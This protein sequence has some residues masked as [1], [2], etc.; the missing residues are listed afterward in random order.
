MK[1]SDDFGLI[2]NINSVAGHV[3]PFLG[4]SLNMYAP[5]KHA[6]TALTETIRQELIIANNKKVRITV[7]LRGL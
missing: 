4:Y 7:S 5:S 6:V 3:I 2:V 1:K